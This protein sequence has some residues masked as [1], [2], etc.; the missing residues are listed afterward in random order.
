[1]IPV[2]K[3]R[4]RKVFAYTSKNGDYVQLVESSQI[5]Q[6]DSYS[7]RSVI[8]RRFTFKLFSNYFEALEHFEE[9]CDTIH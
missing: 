4:T 2:D 9:V 5:R 7:V 1:M 6:N 3:I 8:N